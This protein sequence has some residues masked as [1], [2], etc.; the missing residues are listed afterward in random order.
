LGFCY[1]LDTANPRKII[2]VFL[3]DRKDEDALFESYGLK[4]PLEIIYELQ[5][6]ALKLIYDGKADPKNCKDASQT[7]VVWHLKRIKEKRPPE[8]LPPARGD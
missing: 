6:D 2:H 3:P 4:F 5:G 8:H 7:K 1:R